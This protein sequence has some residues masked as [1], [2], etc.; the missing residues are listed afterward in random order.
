MYIFVLLQV[1]STLGTEPAHHRSA[2]QVNRKSCCFV[3]LLPSLPPYLPPI[4]LHSF[5]YPHSLPPSQCVAYIAA[6]ELPVGQWPDVIQ[7]LLTNVSGVQSTEAVKEA[8]LEAIG[9]ICEEVVSWLV[10][11]HTCM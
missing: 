3:Q 2:A 11:T 1:F 8:S 10:N 7:S 4:P 5:F 9:Y 6:A